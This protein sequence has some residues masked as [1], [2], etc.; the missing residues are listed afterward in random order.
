[1]SRLKAALRALLARAGY[2]VL[3]TESYISLQRVAAD[4]VQDV[5]EGPTGRTEAGEIYT[6]VFDYDGLRTDPRVIHNHDFMRDP[7]YVRAYKIAHQALGHDYKM[8]WRLHVALWCASHAAKLPG[9]FVEC[10]VW[11]GFLSTAIVDYLDWKNLGKT[12]YLFDTFADLDERYLTESERANTQKIDHFKKFYVDCYEFVR[13]HFAQ[14]ERIQII[15]G[16]VPETL[17]TVDVE[18]VAYLSIDMNCVQPE[19]AAA[20]YFWP[21]MTPGAVMLLDDYGFVS[22][23]EQKR[24]FDKFASQRGVEILALPTGQGL[25]IK[26]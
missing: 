17:N 19:I 21:K 24:G 11:R 1:M 7:R 4:L 25:L 9:D 23:E 26:S 10:G 18:R 14:Y 6:A 3:R 12:F 15:R 16:T 2:T 5:S 8:F 20:E 13:H 22:Y